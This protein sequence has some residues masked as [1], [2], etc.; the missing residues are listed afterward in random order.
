MYSTALRSG[1]VYI[2]PEKPF[3]G[4]FMQS[5]ED[6]EDIDDEIAELGAGDHPNGEMDSEGRPRT[7]VASIAKQGTLLGKWKEYADG[8][9]EDEII[10]NI[11]THH[12]AESTHAVMYGKQEKVLTEDSKAL[13]KELRLKAAAREQ[14]ESNFAPMSS[15]RPVVRSDLSDPEGTGGGGGTFYQI[16]QKQSIKDVDVVSD[17]ESAPKKKERWYKKASRRIKHPTRKE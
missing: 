6:S 13:I 12:A 16:P 15:A 4:R 11:Y 14:T 17:E 5:F 9:D 7:T 3:F 1:S 8:R 10:N 2:M